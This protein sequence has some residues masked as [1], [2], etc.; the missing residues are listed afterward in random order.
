MKKSWN[1]WINYESHPTAT[2]FIHI[3]RSLGMAYKLPSARMFFLF[4]YYF[5]R[6][7]AV[8][9]FI[10]SLA[11]FRWNYL[12]V[13]MCSFALFWSFVVVVCMS[14]SLHLHLLMFRIAF[15]GKS[16]LIKLQL[17]FSPIP[18]V[19]EEPQHVYVRTFTWIYN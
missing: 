2:Y 7:G 12:F 11:F 16:V 13:S 14:L 9:I 15:R 5:F 3:D 6:A 17:L 8:F 18:N 10:F 4:L 1:S 19:I